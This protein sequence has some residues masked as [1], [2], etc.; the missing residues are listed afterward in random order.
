LAILSCT[1]PIQTDEIQVSTLGHH[2]IVAGF[3]DKLKL[4]ERIDARIPVSKEAHLTYGQR[5][6][7]MIINGLGFTQNPMYLSPHFFEDKPL[8]ALIGEGIKPEHINDDSLGRALDVC[9][10]YG[11]TQLFAELANEISM[12]F[13]PPQDHPQYSHLDTTSLK[14]SGDYDLEQDYPDEGERPSLPKRGHSKDH[15]PDLKQM[16]LSLMVSGPADLPI[17]FE[18][19]DGNSQD[20][21]NFHETLENIQKFRQGLENCPALTIVADSAL[22]TKDQLH[23]AIYTWVTRIPESVKP[24]KQLV[25]S[26]HQ[27]FSWQP[28]QEGY[29][30]A[31]FGLD[32]RGLRQHCLLVHSEQAEKRESI[33]LMHR[34]TKARKKAEIDA[35]RLSR[36]PFACRRDA[37]KA[38]ENFE[39]KLK[40][41]AIKYEV[42]PVTRFSGRGRPRKTDEP[43]LSHFNVKLT[44]IE[45]QEKLRSYRNKLGRFV[46]STNALDDPQMDAATLLATYKSQQSVER[47]FRLIKDP[48][49]HLNGIFLKKPERINALMM[50]MALCLM[51]YNAGQYQLRKSLEE[52][53]ETVLNQVGKPT[54]KPTLKWLF[55]RMNGIHLISIPGVEACVTGLTAEKEKILKLCGKEVARIYKLA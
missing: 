55:Q 31:W 5:I 50:I 22:Y 19:L 51:V 42:I 24:V 6:K 8:A 34:V 48:E 32:D 46:L 36:Q 54:D 26:D 15:R 47:G 28:L 45:C 43:M 11:V 25:H 10:E 39:A 52:Q 1:H 2:G 9:Y 30:G 20:K 37:T 38:A 27:E 14:L 33:S 4:V 41:H 29:S 3:V 23:Q 18:G 53:Q 44:L 40:Y 49:L 12:E 16:V 35:R 17:W 7:A 13:S 21:S